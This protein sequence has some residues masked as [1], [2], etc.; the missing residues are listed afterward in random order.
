MQHTV[1]P[2]YNG[3]TF[4]KLGPVTLIRKETIPILEVGWK[5]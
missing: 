3:K 5:A 4:E 2:L 1:W